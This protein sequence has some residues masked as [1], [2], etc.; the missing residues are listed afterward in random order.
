MQGK[1]GSPGL[2]MLAVVVAAVI[3]AAVGFVLSGGG[4]GKVDGEGKASGTVSSPAVKVS[5]GNAVPVST[6]LA[7]ALASTSPATSAGA[8]QAQIAT[9]LEQ[10]NPTQRLAALARVLESVT[11]ANWREG[12]TIFSEQ[13]KKFGRSHYQEWL[14]YV[15]R[16]GE[17]AGVEAMKHF[18]AGDNLEA[19]RA[20]LTGWAAVQPK[21]A[22][23]WI[24]TEAAPGLR[25]KIFGAAVRGIVQKDAGLGIALVEQLPLE[26][27]HNYTRGLMDSIVQAKGIEPAV[28]IFNGIAQRAQAA[29]ALDS[30][31]V[32]SSFE[33]LAERVLKMNRMNQAPERSAAWLSAHLGRPYVGAAGGPGGGGLC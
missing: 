6:G 21:A 19:S 10:A 7:P 8:L 2:V 11:P 16:A 15:E 26:V 24:E 27:R 14:L 28:E 23:D 18:A 20:C 31:Y 25:D 17:V 4:D 5:G 33:Q 12:L 13:A 32:R 22:V 9:A 1:S 3:A 30:E 29:G